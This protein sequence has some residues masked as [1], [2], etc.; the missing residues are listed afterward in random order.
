MDPWE[1]YNRRPVPDDGVPWPGRHDALLSAFA[2]EAAR[3]EGA[4]VDAMAALE[5]LSSLGGEG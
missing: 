1:V 3:R 4:V 2:E 5:H